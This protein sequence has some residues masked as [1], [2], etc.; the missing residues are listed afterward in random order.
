M[1]DL[2]R[3]CQNFL[4]LLNSV[5]A[6]AE[7][8]GGNVEAISGYKQLIKHMC[9][10]GLEI[11]KHPTPATVKRLVV[12]MEV[13]KKEGCSYACRLPVENWAVCAA[14]AM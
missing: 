11:G 7:Q 5:T 13:S 2:P 4:P 12:D 3:L 10:L 8:N 1:G 9:T 6:S 14:V